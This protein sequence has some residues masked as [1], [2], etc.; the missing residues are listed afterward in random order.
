MGATVGSVGTGKGS[1]GSVVGSGNRVGRPN[2]FVGDALGGVATGVGVGVGVAE[3][4]GVAAGGTYCAGFFRGP[5]AAMA[6]PR[7]SDV[8]TRTGPRMTENVS[9]LER[10]LGGDQVFGCFH[11]K[12]S[13]PSTRRTKPMAMTTI[14]ISHQSLS[15]TIS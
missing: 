1:V 14:E 5:H 6:R 15:P 9:P 2:G 12:R 3:G 7:T 8:T 10:P 13:L 11:S 4:S